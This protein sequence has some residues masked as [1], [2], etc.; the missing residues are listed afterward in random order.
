M[1]LCFFTM[2][3]ANTINIV[4]GLEMFAQDNFDIFVTL[5]DKNVSISVRF[6]YQIPKIFIRH[7]LRRVVAGQEDKPAQPEGKR[8][9]R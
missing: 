3:Q 1:Q 9:I 8:S 4:V 2:T 5:E 7:A 6:L